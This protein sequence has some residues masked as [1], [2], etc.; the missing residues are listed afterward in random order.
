MPDTLLLT[1]GQFDLDQLRAIYQHQ[2]DLQLADECREAI[3]RSAQTVSQI[4]ADQRTVYGINTGFGLLARTSIPEAQLATL[5]RNLILSH[6]TG[7]GPL[8]DDASVALIMALKIGS[9]ARGFSGVGPAVIETLLKLYRARVYP[10]IPSQGSVGA[11][12][13]LAPLAHM[14]APLLGVGQVRHE[15]RILEASEGLAIAGAEPLV[16]GPKEGLA[17]INGTQ[18]STALA[19]RGLFAAERLFISAVVAGSL[20]V[21]ALKGSFVPFDARIQEVRGQPGQIAVAAL[22]RELLHDSPINHSHI[23]CK[24]VQD[25]YSLR[26]Q[27][28]VMGACLDHLRFAASV[29]LREANAV[30]DN[31]LVFSADGDVL[32]GGNFHAEPVA[33]ASDVLALA[34]AEIG[35]LS[36]RRIAQLVDPAMSGLPAFLVKE[37]GLNS[38]F[39]IA[40]VTSAALA[41]E[42]KTWAHPASVDSLPT[43][44]NQE[45]HVSM[46][47][48]AARRLQD[49][50]ANSAGVVAIELLAAA[51]GV[52]FHA[53]LQ[54]SPQLQE[55][56][57]LIRSQVPHYEQDRYF[58]PDIAAARAW[59]EE[60][61]MSRWIGYSRLYS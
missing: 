49:M 23:D 43:S 9:L 27:P 46:A 17:L 54:S 60:G 40:Q 35:A 51:Q 29:F 25:P 2:P 11:S 52:D 30:S 31:P 20:S 44:A 47:T 39:M 8:L 32:S 50:A 61:V 56:R 14:S 21:E 16:L 33:M 34:I 18:V 48:F 13:D 42:N 22:Y 41:S 53:P 19:L 59:V 24:R 58:A 28:Q 7:T 26:C 1:P 38:G 57:T 6:C 37:G 45:D 12:G 3:L 55:V 4:I 15:G 10:C 5:Q 36:E